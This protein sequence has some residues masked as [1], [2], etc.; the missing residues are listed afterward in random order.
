MGS[1]WSSSGKNSQDSLRWESS[2]RFK[3]WW[4]NQSVNLSNSK[5][6]SLS[7]QCTVA[8]IS[9]HQC[10][11]KRR[12]K[13]QERILFTL[14]EV[15][16]RLSWFFALLFLSIS[17]V[18]RSSFRF[19]QRIGQRLTKC[20]GT[21]WKWELGVNGGTDRTFNANAISQTEMSVQGSWLRDYEPK[22]AELPEDEK[23][24]KL[25][26]DAGFMKDTGQFFITLGEEEPDGMQTLCREY[27][28]PR[29][30]ETSRARGWIRGNTKNGPVLDVK[31]YCH[32]E[33]YCVDTM[34]ESSLRENSFSGS[35]RERYQQIRHRHDRRNSCWEHWTCPYRETCS[36]GQAT[37]KALCDIVSCCFSCSWK[38]MGCFMIRW[39]RHEETIPREDDGAVRFDLVEF[40]VKFVG[41]SEWTVDAWTTF[42]HKK[43]GGRKK[44]FQ[45]CLNPK[46]SKH[47]LYFRAIQGHSGGAV[48]DPSLQ[49]N[50]LLPDDF[51]V[52]IYHIGNAHDMH[53]I[54][55]GGLIPGGKSHKRTDRQC[56][57]QPR[58]RRTSVKIWKKF[59]T[60]WTNP[61][62]QCTK[63]RGNLTKIQKSGA[64]WSSL[65]AKDCSFIKL[66]HMQSFFSTHYL[67][68]VLRMW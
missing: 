45:L 19:M 33:R 44:R 60:I 68:F 58:T 64:S 36:G 62:S 54:I 38:E 35:C 41:T 26:S 50:V 63:A 8:S 27:I 14:T 5:E 48:V 10:F 49:D 53:S 56:F 55:Q 17:S 24:T 52:Y 6:G 20:K 59:N 25:C 67:R 40:K 23:L 32:Q 15:K 51:A 2:P 31:V 13:K 29:D 46:Y 30:Q 61:G 57:S 21:R 34:I 28:L 3:K 22:F 4:R 18:L 7:C 12:I 47:F 1:R 66:D 65:R 39:L 43:R 16:K 11:G 9:R 42:L 37:T